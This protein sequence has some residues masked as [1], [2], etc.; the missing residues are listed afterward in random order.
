MN[1]KRERNWKGMQLIQSLYAFSPMKGLPRLFE[2]QRKEI[3]AEVGCPVQPA[4]KG[5]LLS[6]LDR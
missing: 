5:Q 6:R 2:T 1:Q 3:L 4:L